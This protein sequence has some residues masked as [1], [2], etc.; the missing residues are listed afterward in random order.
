MQLHVFYKKELI[1]IESNLNFAIPWWTSCKKVDNNI[2]FKEV[3]NDENKTGNT[4]C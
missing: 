1:C 3:S 4:S 2:T